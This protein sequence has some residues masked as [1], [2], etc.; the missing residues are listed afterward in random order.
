MI[1]RLEIENFYCIR[2]RQV[3]DLTVP[4]TTPENPERFAPIFKGADL[5]APKVVAVFGANGSGKSTVLKALALLIWFV[6][7]SFQHTAPGLPCERFNDEESANRPIRL[8]IEFG[9]QMELTRAAIEGA[10]KGQEVPYGVYR[11][12]IEFGI[13]DG[14]VKSVSKEALRQKQ[15][16]RG[17]WQRVF[18]R[19]VGQKL[20]GSS[21]FPLSGYARIIDKIRDDSSVLSTLTIFEHEP[22]QIL[23]DAASGVV[24]NILLDKTELSDSAVVQ[25]LA[26]HPLLVTELNKELQRIDV[27]I[28]DMQIIQTPNGP[29]PLFKH[30]GLLV[31]MPWNLESHGTRSFIRM[32]PLLLASL[33]SGGSAIIDELDLSIHP[34]ILPEMVRWYYDPDRNARHA[35]LWM[36]CQSASLLEDLMKEE[37]VLCEK[38][39]RGRSEIYSLTDVKAV[40]RTDNLYKKYLGGVYGAVPHIG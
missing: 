25:H 11:Y 31:D 6:K 15:Q 33:M 9:G 3:L 23:V 26:R 12:E 28:Q 10:A 22:S 8:A 35:Q 32:F 39:R 19:Q 29:A 17:K 38:D 14:V 4:R 20:L 1:Y 13:E 18:E 16:G 27:G 24:S 40:R 2:D 34:L 36:T 5:R 7:D 30:E 21:V 37:I